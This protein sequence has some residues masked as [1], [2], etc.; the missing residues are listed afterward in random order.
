MSRL[1][2]VASL[3]PR[4]VREVWDAVGA[5]PSGARLERI[6]AS[7]QWH[8]GSFHN[9]TSTSLEVQAD[10]E[11]KAEQRDA[12]RRYL[13]DREGRRPVRPIPVE[14]P[15]WGTAGVGELHLTWLGHASSLVDI[16]GARVLI[17]PVFGDRAAPSQ[18]IGPKRLHPAPCPTDAL[19]ELDVIV[20]SHDHYDHLCTP[21]VRALAATQT[22][23]FV[24]A[25]GVGAHLE[26]WGVPPERIIELDWDESHEVAG[27]QVT[28]TPAQHFSG[29]GLRRNGTLWASWVLAGP[30]HRVFYS[31]DTGYCDDFARIGETHGPFDLTLIQVGAYDAGW[32]DIHMTPEE[33]VRTHVDLRGRLVVP[34]HW[35]T[36]VLAPHPWAEPAELMLA[37][38]AEA[39]VEVAVPRL[40]ARIDVGAP[41][42]TDP[43]WRAA[44][45]GVRA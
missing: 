11:S 36:F 21:T 35:G 43:W 10:A 14:R 42:A 2:A 7:P 39:G 38:A 9:R 45:G 18:H 40:G 28:A 33:G 32:P 44:A 6:Q 27:L 12:F 17:D 30:S 8:G 3:T 13:L 15:D 25:L 34:V 19:P 16:D 23:P 20:V 24:T 26:A 41:F 31:G 5:A 4:P 29:R 1:K 22:A 37:A